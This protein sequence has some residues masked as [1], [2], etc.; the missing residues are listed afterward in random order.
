[1]AQLINSTVLGQFTFLFLFSAH[2]KCVKALIEL[3][4]V[5]SS[6]Q[7]KAAKSHFNIL[8]GNVCEENTSLTD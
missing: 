8:L 3:K 1:M 7:Y 4:I 2:E 6:I 5:L